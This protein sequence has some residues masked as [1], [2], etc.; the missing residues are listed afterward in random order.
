MG[1]YLELI[2]ASFVGSY[3]KGSAIFG[4]VTMKPF[5]LRPKEGFVPHSLLFLNNTC[6]RDNS[7]TTARWVPT[8]VRVKYRSTPINGRKS[9][10]FTGVKYTCRG[11][12]HS[13]CNWLRP[14]WC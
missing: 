8:I 4:K 10:D 14:T 6:L 7:L 1:T 11:Y 12:F 9:M 2:G 3:S 13:I 5:I